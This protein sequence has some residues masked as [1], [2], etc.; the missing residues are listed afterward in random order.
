MLS[1]R[2]RRRLLEEQKLRKGAVDTRPDERTGLW[3]I[4]NAPITLW[5]LSTVAIGL[6]SA[7]IT[8]YQSCRVEF[9]KDSMDF[10]KLSDEI[11]GRNRLLYKKLAS[12]ATETEYNSAIDAFLSGEIFYVYSEHKGKSINEL[13][14]TRTLLAKKL[15]PVWSAFWLKKFNITLQSVNGSKR[16]LTSTSQLEERIPK[17]EVETWPRQGFF[18]PNGSASPM[19]I[20]MYRMRGFGEEA[21]RIYL[22]Y[23]TDDAFKFYLAYNN[24]DAYIDKGEYWTIP[25]KC[26]LIS[27]WTGFFQ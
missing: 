24:P 3:K 6:I 23:L 12:S 26:S 10:I 7:T 20:G 22:E 15:H 18:G 13:S 19:D 4:A 25:N 1:Y 17:I 21:D 9:E 11:P 16:M 14:L 8:R 5:L 27:I 2:E